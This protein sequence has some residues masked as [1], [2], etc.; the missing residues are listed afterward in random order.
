VVKLS[1]LGDIIHT[2]PA[3]T[4]AAAAVPGVRFDWVVEEAFAEVPRWHPAVG[5]VIPVALR[6]WRRRP[7]RALRGAEWSRA[8]AALGAQGYDKVIDAQGLLKSAIVARL[9]RGARCG[10][11]GASARERLAGAPR[12]HAVRVPRDMHAVD[13]LRLL[14]ARA[15]VYPRPAQEVDY[16]LPRRGAAPGRRDASDLVFIHGSARGEKLW[17]QASWIDLAARAARAGYRVSLPWGDA[18]ERRGRPRYRAGSPVR[19][20]RP[21]DGV[22]LR[23]DAT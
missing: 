21:A 3:V 1:S 13:R 9:A 15:L 4:D 12:R 5:R 10:M 6:R 16:G 23:A 18:V 8:R 17:P 14:F 2:L 19:R 22:T 20:P 11:D 7:W